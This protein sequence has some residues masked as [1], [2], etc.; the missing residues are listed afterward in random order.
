MSF[1]VGFV[2]FCHVS[3]VCNS[4]LKN[5][6]KCNFT[7]FQRF[8]FSPKHFHCRVMH[9]SCLIPQHKLH[10]LQSH[11]IYCMIPIICV[12]FS[13]LSVK[14][15]LIDPR[16]MISVTFSSKPNEYKF[17]QRCFQSHLQI[18]AFLGNLT[19]PNLY[20]FPDQFSGGFWRF[21]PGHL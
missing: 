16:S 1:L 19:G 14:Y 21:F 15:I 4:P 7:T 9:C 17:F 10:T 5:A 20:K 13:R 8:L 11:K 3:F 18:Y 6:V 12:N 2:P